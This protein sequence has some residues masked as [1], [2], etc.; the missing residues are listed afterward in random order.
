VTPQELN[1]LL[2]KVESGEVLSG[3]ELHALQRE[4][5]TQGGLSLRLSVAHA[6]LNADATDPAL[7]LLGT[8]EKDFPSDAQV[9]LAIARAHFAVE[10]YS[11]AEPPLKRVLKLNPAD[12]EA[13]KGLALIA[14]R[15]GERSR[16]MAL[17]KEVLDKDPFDS[18]AQQL[19]GELE[20]GASRPVAL[21]ASLEEF[22]KA[23]R[24][25]LAS[26]AVTHLIQKER[27]FLKLS[28]GD[29][30]RMELKGL[31][32]SYMDSGQSLDEAVRSMTEELTAQ[33]LGLPLEREELLAKVL[34]VLRDDR[35]AQKVGG[36]LSRE[37]PGGLWLFYAMEHPDLM[38]YLPLTVTRSHGVSLDDVDQA[39]WANLAKSVLALHAI[40]F[41]PKALALA[42]AP[43]GLWA[44]AKGDGHDAARLLLP[45]VQLALKE[46]LGE[47]AWRVYLGLRE[48]VLLCREDDTDAI[49][50]LDGLEAA[51]DG[52]A[53]AYVFHQSSL[54]ALDEWRAVK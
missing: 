3:D 41:D 42:S 45:N 11:D 8:L 30:A 44:L 49:A 27:L 50:K 28:D 43:T 32:Q 16:A 51:G 54:K 2:H 33:V 53:G 4:A 23:L 29:V 48:L 19:S 6:L 52:I 15:R 39:A 17:V 9:P 35:F 46:K 12:L 24:A 10:R 22:V 37:G 20:E 7:R 31:H 13:M 14:M 18:E 47:G 26:H 25:G 40:E 1:R 38:R 36:L 5:S 34:P 21:L